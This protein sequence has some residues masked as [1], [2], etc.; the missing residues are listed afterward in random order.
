MQRVW[1]RASPLQCVAKRLKIRL[2]AQIL[3]CLNERRKTQGN[4]SGIFPQSLH[5]V[6]KKTGRI[7]TKLSY[8]QYEGGYSITSATNPIWQLP[9]TKDPDWMEPDLWLAE[10]S[11]FE[12]YSM[13]KP[14]SKT[15]ASRTCR[16]DCH[17]DLWA[18]EKCGMK[19]VLEGQG[20]KNINDILAAAS[21]GNVCAGSIQPLLRRTRL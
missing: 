15:N 7:S 10:R 19:K 4:K 6:K 5:R 12:Y 3:N 2:Y 16:C 11:V 18:I 14:A 20:G 8:S 13:K 21:T 17:S 9:C 1:Y